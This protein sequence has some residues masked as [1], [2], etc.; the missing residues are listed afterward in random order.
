MKVGPPLSSEAIAMPEPLLSIMIVNLGLRLPWNGVGRTMDMRFA[1]KQKTICLPMHWVGVPN[2]SVP[3][4]LSFMERPLLSIVFQDGGVDLCSPLSIFARRAIGGGKS[5]LLIETIDALFCLIGSLGVASGTRVA[6]FR[7]IIA[8]QLRGKLWVFRTKPRPMFE[9]NLASSL[10]SSGN[11]LKLLSSEVG[12]LWPGI[13]LANGARNLNSPPSESG[14]TP[15]SQLLSL[16][17]DLCG[18]FGDRLTCKICFEAGLLVL[19][20]RVS[21]DPAN[22]VASHCKFFSRVLL[23][24][25]AGGRVVW[26]AGCFGVAPEL[27]FLHPSS[28]KQALPVNLSKVVLVSGS[29]QTSRLAPSASFLHRFLLSFPQTQFG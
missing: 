21:T 8:F 26:I 2:S 12:L 27:A 28:L 18:V 11:Q 6:N 3:R 19:L 23:F 15:S 7:K 22:F 10:A 13:R 1:S 4:K 25:A 29:R 24:A 16:N 5:S 20:G 17:S 9:L 14:R